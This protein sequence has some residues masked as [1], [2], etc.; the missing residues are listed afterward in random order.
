MFVANVLLQ[1]LL[2]PPSASLGAVF[3]A[4]RRLWVLNELNK[5]NKH[6]KKSQCSRQF[7]DFYSSHGC[8]CASLSML[9]D[10]VSPNKIPGFAR[11][12]GG[13]MAVSWRK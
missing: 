1:P 9:A 12:A 13:L 7:K 4:L 10:T 8:S 3:V 5:F 6:S 2:A 11:R